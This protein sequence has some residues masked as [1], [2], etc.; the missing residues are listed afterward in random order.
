MHF[1][2][3]FRRQCTIS[4]SIN[5]PLPSPGRRAKGERSPLS[6]DEE[7]L[8]FLSAH[9]YCDESEKRNEKIFHFDS[10]ARFVRPFKMLGECSFPH[11]QRRPA[12]ASAEM[13]PWTWIVYLLFIWLRVL[14]SLAFDETKKMKH[15]ISSFCSVRC[16]YL[17]LQLAFIGHIVVAFWIRYAFSVVSEGLLRSVSSSFFHTYVMCDSSYETGKIDFANSPHRFDGFATYCSP[18][19]TSTADH[20]TGICSIGPDMIRLGVA[21]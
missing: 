14:L 2:S 18:A 20:R 8:C 17:P 7:K 6:P 11:F 5:F 4:S 1:A 19:Q 13:N 12:Q 10:F 9:F 16:T 21:W 3:L 15:F